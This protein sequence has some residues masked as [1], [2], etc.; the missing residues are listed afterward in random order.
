[1]QA[2]LCTLSRLE[3]L[4]AHD[5]DTASA[6]LKRRERWER[7]AGGLLHRD[8]RDSGLDDRLK[9]REMR[10]Q[11]IVAS[12]LSATRFD[13]RDSETILDA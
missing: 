3:L 13:E 12:A 10:G 4:V 9:L 6:S 11:G 1:M 2:K 8:H 5:T 7:A